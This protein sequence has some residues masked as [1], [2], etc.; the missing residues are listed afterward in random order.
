MMLNILSAKKAGQNPS[1]FLRELLQTRTQLLLWSVAFFMA[2]PVV[3]MSQITGYSANRVVDGVD[4][5]KDIA[6][7]MYAAMWVMLA[8]GLVAGVAA[9][10]VFHNKK[11]AYFFLSLPVTR[12]ELFVTRVITGA[13]P[14]V[15][16]YLANV[17]VSMLIFAASPHFGFFEIIPAFVKLGAQTLLIY[18]WVYA[19]TVFAASLTSRG[20]ANLLLTVWIYLILPAYQLSLWVLFNLSAP[21]AYLPWLESENLFVYTCPLARMVL[22][23]NNL[24]DSYT[25]PYPDNIKVTDID[26]YA[27]L[28]WYEVVLI[29]AVSVLLIVAAAFI[30]KKRPAENSGESAV[31]RKVGEIIKLTALIP[32]GI[33]FGLFFNELFGIIGLFFGV[34]WG[35]FV[36]FLIL[37][38]L[39]YRSGKKLF[40]GVKAAIFL[41][42]LLIVL[43]I[44]FLVIGDRI[45]NRE[46]TSEN[47]ESISV[48]VSPFGDIKLDPERSG[49]LLAYIS[50]ASDKDDDDI[51]TTPSVL[52]N[53]A[54][55]EESFTISYNSVIY[56]M[57][58][59]SKNYRFIL[60]P[61]FGIGVQKRYSLDEKGEK[62]LFDAMRASSKD[63]IELLAALFPADEID[64][65]GYECYM[66]IAYQFAPIYN[67]IYS[68]SDKR[69]SRE[70]AAKIAERRSKE[71]LNGE[72]SGFA[73]GYIEYCTAD[74][75]YV[76]LPIY[77]TDGDILGIDFCT[78]EFLLEHIVKV[79]VT[80]EVL[81]KYSDG[82]ATE[83]LEPQ[84][85]VYTDKETIAECFN[86]SV[87]ASNGSRGVFNRQFSDITYTFEIN[88]NGISFTIAS[89]PHSEKIPQF[90]YELLNERMTSVQ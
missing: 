66:Y 78:T 42:V 4:K 72:M 13:V 83:M 76:S 52:I 35:V 74:N 73:V 12:N 88:Y 89:H 84:L 36:V 26:F 8:A 45:E 63:G 18:F 27:S 2:L 65:L 11:S 77:I 28:A 6:T 47:T 86:S 68:E 75:G 56:E 46:Y 33:L 49:E 40:T 57:Y 32:A 16:A 29:F 82:R 79:T 25:R 51:F 34:V 70:T 54:V 39:L 64:T 20:G 24:G 17:F 60:K 3:S 67:N 21:N 69:I 30:L 15:A 7:P 43:V 37:N 48:Y 80:S 23:Q 41:T 90:V 53:S 81:Y 19:F 38:L 87:G 10:S 61:K 71:F 55:P 44:A 1:F 58:D 59:Y 85:G 22:L 62:L 31:F 5:L 50:S 14:A 9:F